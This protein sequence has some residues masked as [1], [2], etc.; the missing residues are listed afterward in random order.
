MATQ[1]TLYIEDTD[2]KLL[3]TKSRQIEKWASLLLEPGLV[4]DG[5]ILDEDQVAQKIRELLKLQGV[6]EKRV[7]A[8]LSGLNSIFRVISLPELPQAILLEAIKNEANRVIPMPLEQIYLGHQI[9]PSP[10]GE[11]RAFLV[12]FPRNAT[13]ALLKRQNAADS[14]RLTE[15]FHS[16]DAS[17]GVTQ[18]S[19]HKNASMRAF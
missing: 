4:S 5:V 8:A 6:G 1:V 17:S 3:V 10:P 13:N 14:F 11:T 9:L 12:A 16:L 18:R 7:I 19:E 15:L 2:I